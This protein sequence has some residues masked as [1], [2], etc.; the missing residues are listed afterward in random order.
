MLAYCLMKQQKQFCVYSSTETGQTAEFYNEAMI[1]YK[2]L[3]LDKI[4][5][6][7]LSANTF[8][9]LMNLYPTFLSQR[10]TKGV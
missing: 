2:T 10:Q 5:Y 9:Y 1:C 4:W 6:Y 7:E 3:L 8:I